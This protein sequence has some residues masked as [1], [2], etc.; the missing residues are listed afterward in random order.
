MNL[1][2]NRIV[3]LGITL[4]V[5]AFGLWVFRDFGLWQGFRNLHLGRGAM[6]G[7][8]M[9]VVMILF[10]L[11]VLTAVIA[12]ISGVWGQPGRRGNAA[13]PDDAL[14]ILRQRYARGEIDSTEYNAMRRDLQN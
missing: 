7:S 6:T 4:A 5:I 3:N 12:L 13:G 10:W 14:E 9:G 11:I 2:R 1:R 8:G